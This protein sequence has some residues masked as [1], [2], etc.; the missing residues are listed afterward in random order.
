MEKIIAIGKIRDKGSVRSDFIDF[1]RKKA[2]PRQ[3]NTN[4]VKPAINIS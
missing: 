2:R 4:P 1:G 3:N